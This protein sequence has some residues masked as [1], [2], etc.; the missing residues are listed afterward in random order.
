MFLHKSIRLKDYNYTSG[1]GYFIT[2]CTQNREKLFG[3][4]I[5]EEML[6]NDVGKITQKYL[7]EISS[8]FINIVIDEYIIMP[9][10]IH[11][12]IILQKTDSRSGV[13]CNA[14][15]K[16]NKYSQIS[17]KPGSLSAA[18]RSY[19][20]AVTRWCNMNNHINF[21]WQRG[22]YDHV[23]RNE[24]ELS[25]IR[26]YIQNN[27]LKWHLDIENKEINQKIESLKY[28][29]NIYENNL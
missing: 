8:H 2:I 28:Y 19:K 22:Y 26:E 27:P 29:Q 21:K 6:L 23:I 4:I 15:T 3:D 1:G 10:H 20:S 16:K 13:T 17:P 5:D 14:S 11:S 12:I 9:N 24:I 18:I 7:V 25:H